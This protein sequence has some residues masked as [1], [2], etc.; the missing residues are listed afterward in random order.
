M[1][2]TSSGSQRKRRP[3]GGWRSRREPATIGLRFNALVRADTATR[4]SSTRRPVHPLHGAGST[5]SPQTA[6]RIV[7]LAIRVHIALR[8]GPIR[9][10]KGTNE[11]RTRSSPAM[12]VM[13]SFRNP[14]SRLMLLAALLFAAAG[15]SAQS[16]SPGDGLLPVTR[17][18]ALKAT[19]EKPGR[20]ALHFDIAKHYYL[21]RGRIHAKIL[22]SGITAGAIDLPPGKQEHDPFL[23]DVEIYHDSVDATLPYS[24]P[25]AMPPT[26][27][28]TVSYQGCHEVTPKICYPPN[29]ETFTLPTSGGG[30]VGAGPGGGP[31]K[32]AITATLGATPSKTQP[33]SAGQKW[34]DATSLAG[35]L[36]IGR[37]EEHT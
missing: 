24:A 37:S 4:C 14:L 23:G 1:S 36:S 15:A 31:G 11:G 9:A 13:P 25:G 30:P 5:C 6:H 7:R 28:V 29:A 8:F 34:N 27:K 12:I 19:V 26:L 16:A 33:P 35:P 2:R 17:A 32:A 3:D 22:T 10:F 21:Y 20:I 18:F